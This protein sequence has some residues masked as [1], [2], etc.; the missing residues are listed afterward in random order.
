MAGKVTRFIGRA[1]SPKAVRPPWM[2]VL[3]GRRGDGSYST[4]TTNSVNREVYTTPAAGGPLSA[5]QSLSPDG[6]GTSGRMVPKTEFASHRCLS[7]ESWSVDL[8]DEAVQE[9]DFEYPCDLVGISV[10]TC[11]APRAYEIAREFRKRGKTVVLGGVH[12]TYCPEEANMGFFQGTGNAIT[13][14]AVLLGA[15]IYAGN[16]QQRVASAE[17][18]IKTVRDQ[19][20]QAGKT[21]EER[22]VRL[23]DKLEG[24]SKSSMSL[25]KTSAI[26]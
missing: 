25:L 1:F 20:I 11:Y 4:S 10:M 15:A 9:V 7:P 19:A 12:P 21:S 14:I 8:V 24:F 5:Q 17:D 16:L 23:Y 26:T 6:I 3:M 18:E 22:I 2:R 13:A